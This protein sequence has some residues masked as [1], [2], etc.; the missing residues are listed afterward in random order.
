M[1]CIMAAGHA[2]VGKERDPRGWMG[3]GS[4]NAYLAL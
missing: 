3:S 2:E 4:A 1:V